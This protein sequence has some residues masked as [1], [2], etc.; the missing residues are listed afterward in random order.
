MHRP[1]GRPNTRFKLRYARFR[2]HSSDSGG[3]H[4]YV[5]DGSAYRD[6][7]TS[8]AP[9]AKLMAAPPLHRQFRL[10]TPKSRW[11]FCNYA[12]VVTQ[13]LLLSSGRV[14]VPVPSHSCYHPS[15]MQIR[16]S[17]GID[18]PPLFCLDLYNLPVCARGSLFQKMAVYHYLN[19]PTFRVC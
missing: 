2:V 18:V 19:S 5:N 10:Q 14:S 11:N 6:P 9:L 17:K 16:S 15:Q 7:Y 12:R 8:T 3:I 4:A 13:P 1:F